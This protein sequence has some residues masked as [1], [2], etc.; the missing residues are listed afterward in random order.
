MMITWLAVRSIDNERTSRHGHLHR[1]T[2]RPWKQLA[3]LSPPLH[4]LTLKAP[5]RMPAPQMHPRDPDRGTAFPGH[6]PA[7]QGSPEP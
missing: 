1:T 4:H 2:L 3:A 7:E 6:K 5:D